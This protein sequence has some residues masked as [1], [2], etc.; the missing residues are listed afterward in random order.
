MLLSRRFAL[1]SAFAGVSLFALAAQSASVS[2]SGKSATESR[3]L[4]EFQAISLSGSMDM[5]VSQGPQQ[6]VQVSAD[7]N[8]LAL[9]E[10]VVENGKN[11]ATLLVRWKP[12]QSLNTRSKVLVTVV[13]PKLS[14]IGLSG[15]GDARVQSFNTPR[16]EVTVAGSSDVQLPGLNTED[17]SVRIAGSG[18]VRG[19]GKATKLKISVAGSGDA[20]LAD[21]RAED[22]SVSVAGSGD[23]AVQAQKTL[24]VSVAGSGTV[25][26]SGAATVKK[27]IAGS[28]SVTKK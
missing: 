6:Q 27:S 11:G 3:N 26:Y 18:D 2:G 24:D 15:S 19:D 9:L 1:V 8:L 17:L 4:A 16:L 10:T 14:A 28:G 21:L 20:R 23:A 22:V 12:G 7:D 13:V 25:T 5:V